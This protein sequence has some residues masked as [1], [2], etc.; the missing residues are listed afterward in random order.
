MIQY[1]LNKNIPPIIQQRFIASYANLTQ[2]AISN[3]TTRLLKGA[4]FFSLIISFKYL[5][6][7]RKS[8]KN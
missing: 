6:K 8:I 4:L 3:N 7:L 2:K 5:L 1:A